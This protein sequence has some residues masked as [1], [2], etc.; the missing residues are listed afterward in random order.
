S[1]ISLAAL[2]VTLNGKLDRKALPS[3]GK[4]SIEVLRK[5]VAPRND[6]ERRL[7]NIWQEVLGIPS[8]SV[9]DNFFDV[10]GNSLLAVRLF[11]RIE[12]TFHIKLP[13]ATLIE[14][15]TVEQLAGV[16]SEN[17]RRSWSPLVEMQPK[18]SRPPFFCVHGASG[19]VLIYRDLSRHLGTDQ[20]F[21]GLQAQGLDGTAECLTTV[22]D[23]AALDISEIR[24]VQPEWPYLIWVYCL[25]CS[26]SYS[27]A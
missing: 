1:F 21:Y 10:G 2:P 23:M 5:H 24:R 12:K 4:G 26:I 11:T 25:R 20:P 19:N 15:Q 18:G 8:I 9:D 3:S 13:L 16:L 27:F 14:A 7:I 17:V 22:V 6:T